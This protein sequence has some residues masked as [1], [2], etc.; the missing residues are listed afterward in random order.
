ME[1]LECGEGE[2]EELRGEARV[3][4]KDGNGEGGLRKSAQSLWSCCFENAEGNELCFLAANGEAR[5]ARKR[6]AVSLA[7]TMEEWQE[8]KEVM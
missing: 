2:S 3:D 5:R 4:A 7:M 1:D 8:R 6:S